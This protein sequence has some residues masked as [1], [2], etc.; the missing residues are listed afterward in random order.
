MTEGR[1]WTSDVSDGSLT[2]T[3]SSTGRPGRELRIHTEG[4]G[5]AFLVLPGLT[6]PGNSYWARLRLRVDAFPPPRTGRTGPSPQARLGLPT[7]VRPLGGQ[8]APTDHGNFWGVGSDLGPTGDW[9]SAHS[10]LRNR[11]IRDRRVVGQHHRQH[12]GFE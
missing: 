8:Y 5:R 2:V 6:A 4:N 11:R 12:A 9:T 10:R 7:L 3:P 1:G